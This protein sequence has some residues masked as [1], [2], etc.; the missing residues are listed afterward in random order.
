MFT[1]I[2]WLILLFMDKIDP[3]NAPWKIYFPILAVECIIYF[4]LMT[5]WGKI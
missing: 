2:T 4:R 1:S 5:K 3:M